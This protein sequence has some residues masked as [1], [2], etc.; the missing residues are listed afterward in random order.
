M[1]TKNS[2]SPHRR[3]SSSSF[4]SSPL[5]NFQSFLQTLNQI[6][7]K[8]RDSRISSFPPSFN[9]Q[10]FLKIQSQIIT[11][12]TEKSEKILNFLN[13]FLSKLIN[14]LLA[15]CTVN[16]HAQQQKHN[17]SS[18]SFSSSFS[19]ANISVDFVEMNESMFTNFSN[20]REG[21]LDLEN[22][23]LKADATNE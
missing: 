9:F 6:L 12:T 10:H 17:A 5:F 16:K 20:W 19:F 11:K 13:N 15:F 22:R 2:P 7:T 1:E 21:I 14:K 8:K 18:S 4:A 3:D 23:L